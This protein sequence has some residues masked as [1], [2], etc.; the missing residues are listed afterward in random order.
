M[1]SSMP[2]YRISDPP[3]PTV[4]ERIRLL[5]RR[6][7]MTQKELADQVGCSEGSI[8]GWEHDSAQI[9]A[10]KIIQLASYFKVSTDYLLCQRDNET[11]LPRLRWILDVGALNRIETAKRIRDIEDLLDEHG[12]IAVAFE[13][14]ERPLLCSA[15]EARR[16]DRA[17]QQ[18]L[19]RLK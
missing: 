17:I 14:P 9:P 5:R 16:A 19:A 2:T 15:Q 8:R 3:G 7:E 4:G 12:G 11:G 6:A 10:D 13:I 18:L 1:T